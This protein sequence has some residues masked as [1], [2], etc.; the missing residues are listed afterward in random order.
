MEPNQTTKSII[1]I[2]IVLATLPA[3]LY[4]ITYMNEIGICYTYGIPDFLI[5]VSIGNVL[6]FGLSISIFTV[7]ILQSFNLII[8]LHTAAHNPKYKHLKMVLLTNSVGILIVSFILFVNPPSWSIFI[9]AL[10]IVFLMNLLYWIIP[11]ILKIKHP[12]TI[13]DKLSE[14]KIFDNPYDFLKIALNM[15]TPSDRIITLLVVL[16]PF[17]C[18][19][20]GR[21][22]I[23]NKQ[24]FDF[25]NHSKSHVIL[26]KY[27]DLLICGTINRKSKSLADSIFFIKIGD[28]DTVNIITSN[29]GRLTYSK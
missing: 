10:T 18:F 2:S 4:F 6:E 19:F 5:E 8:P 13:Q 17:L 16:L 9:I 15:L 25:I 26:K 23:L 1:S 14:I 3:Y 22:T 29:I 24:E 20:I 7:L 11:L 12:G 28:K 27:G 21:G